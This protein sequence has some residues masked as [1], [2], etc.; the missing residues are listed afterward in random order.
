MS[1]SADVVVVGAGIVG[2]ACVDA[3]AQG[4]LKAAVIESGPI[5]GGTTAACMGHIVVMDD[6]EAQFALTR[7]SADLW[8]QLARELPREAEFTQSGTLWVAAGEEEM[9]EV[10]RKHAYYRERGVEAEILDARALAGA[11]P[12]L[13]PGLA[14]ALRVPRDSVVYPPWI[15]RWLVERSRARV[16]RGEAV[17]ASGTEVR[18]RDGTVCTSGAVVN[19]TGVWAPRL[20]GSLQIQPRKGHLLIT[21]RYPGFLHHQLV[22]LGYLKSAHGHGS[23]SV[24]MN[25]Q[26]RA[27]GQILVGSSRQLGMDSSAIEQHMLR[28][29]LQRAMDYVPG[30]GQLRAT[31]A[32]T[33]LR[34]CSPDNLPYIGPAPEDSSL[35][36][37]AGHEGLGITTSLA[38]ATLIADLLLKRTPAI[39]VAPYSPGRVHAAGH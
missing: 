10:R 1:A 9:A 24:A 29:M 11:E 26:P 15:A 21:D 28:R 35:L 19:A 3:L 16:I 17:A 2:A 25:L 32:W 4:G 22:E 30:L 36:I 33:G 12:N 37:A 8:H 38:T 20:T 18:L 7:Y 5:G 14:G 6:S 34:P 27:T 13:R 31:R 23:E 39:P